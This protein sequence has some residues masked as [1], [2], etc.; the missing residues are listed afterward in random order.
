MLL[1][2]LLLF[3]AVYKSCSFFFFEQSIEW[4]LTF[5]SFPFFF[6]TSQSA[7]ETKTDAS[8]GLVGLALDASKKSTGDKSSTTSLTS[9]ATADV[10]SMFDGL[11]VGEEEEEEEEED[12]EDESDEPEDEDFM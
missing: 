3:L 2:L 10:A 12:D 5:S 9:R 1:Y 8:G 11:D 6:P 4:L 7:G